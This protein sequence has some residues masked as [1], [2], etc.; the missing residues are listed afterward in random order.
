MINLIKDEI[1]FLEGYLKQIRKGKYRTFEARRNG[2]PVKIRFRLKPNDRFR[3]KKLE[4]YKEPLA[5]THN[6]GSTSE[7]KE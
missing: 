4:A 5:M 3:E 1:K 6:T 7:V 2:K